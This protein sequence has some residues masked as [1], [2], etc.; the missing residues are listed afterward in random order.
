MWKTI[1]VLLIL[2]LF[3]TACGKQEA[4]IANPASV[5][6]ESQGGTLSFVEETAGTKGVCTLSDGTVCDEWAFYRGECPEK[7]GADTSAVASQNDSVSESV[8]EQPGQIDASAGE[9]AEAAEVDA[10]A[11]L[12]ATFSKL[13][14]YSYKF[15]TDQ[16][17]VKGDKI[18]VELMNLV[19]LG[20]DEKNNALVVNVLF[21]D[22]TAKKITGYCENYKILLGN[23]AATHEQTTKD[24]CYPIADKTFDLDYETYYVDTP[25][26]IFNRYKAIEPDSVSEEMLGSSITV[27]LNYGDV[28]LKANKKTGIVEEFSVMSDGEK[29]TSFYSVES[30]NQLKDAHMAPVN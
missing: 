7:E 22:T 15:N 10:V 5:Y 17:F 23:P 4:Q 20:K 29:K 19:R 26:D 16:Y 3:L 8:V 1:S 14:S 13:S 25:R 11:E 28:T 24:Y 12:D 18:V 27:V 30:T 9:Q 21:I 6:C 2:L